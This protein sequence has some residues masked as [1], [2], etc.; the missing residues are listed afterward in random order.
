MEQLF[1]PITANV[2]GDFKSTYE[3][4]TEEE[5]KH[6]TLMDYIGWDNHFVNSLA[7]MYYDNPGRI[8]WMGQFATK[9]DF[10]KLS[11]SVDISLSKPIIEDVWDDIVYINHVE[12]VDF[13]LD[14]KYLVNFDKHLYIDINKYKQSSLRKDGTIIHPLPL[15]MAL[16]NKEYDGDFKS[17]NVGY[18][19]VGKWCWQLFGIRDN[20]PKNY[21]EIEIIFAE[22]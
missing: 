21:T 13:T 7:Y 14:D 9:D 16:G 8:C 1:K 17:E 22:A 12:E 5:Q 2:Y 20:I 3:Y 19:H 4:S 18:E 15:L 10:S 6:I 11:T